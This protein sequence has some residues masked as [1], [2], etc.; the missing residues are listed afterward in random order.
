MDSSIP[1]DVAAVRSYYDQQPEHEWQRLERRRTEYAVTLRA[2]R[3]YLPSPPAQ[4]LDCGGGPGH[5]AIELARRGYQITLFDLSSGNL[6]FAHEKAAL[7]CVSLAGYEQGTATDLSR[8]P[9]DGFDAVLLMG[10]LYH[11]LEEEAR[12]KALFEAQRV[13]KAGGVLFAAFISRYAPM[14][15]SAVEDPAWLWQQAEEARMILETGN[16]PPLPG[17]V[18]AFIAHFTHPSEVLPLMQKSRL[19]VVTVLAVEG[20]LSKIEDKVNQLSGTAWE[21]W[22]NLNYQAAGDPCIQGCVENLLAIAVKPL[23]RDALKRVVLM[24]EEAGVSYKVVGGTSATLQGILLPVSD[25]DIETDASGAYRFG[26]LFAVQATRR[27]AFSESEKYRSHFGQFE[28]DGLKFE[29]MGDLQRREGEV[30][31][32]TFTRTETRADLDGVQVRVSWL[33]EE[34]LAYIRRG[35]MDRAALCLARCDQIRLLAILRG[36]VE[37]GVL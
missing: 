33:E 1:S 31:R 22:V 20:L 27:V 30:W 32:P 15:Y 13:L 25:V 7:A 21:A 35:R 23:W 16:R 18:S 11:L 28:I 5:Y 19:E 10:P 2:L 17:D 14:R 24:L 3:E 36:E 12:Q 34:T 9:D 6:N 26:E 37:S 29:I 4:V 8:F